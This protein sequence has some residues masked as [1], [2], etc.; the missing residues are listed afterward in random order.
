MTSRLSSPLRWAVLAFAAG[1]TPPPDEPA[2]K[3]TRPAPEAVQVAEKAMVTTHGF[4]YPDDP[5]GTRRSRRPYGKLVEPCNDW[6]P[7]DAISDANM[8]PTE[9]A[10]MILTSG[11]FD[12]VPGIE[13]VTVSRLTQHLGAPHPAPRSVVIGRATPL[14]R[15]WTWRLRGKPGAT[16]IA[17]AQDD[18]SVRYHFA[19]IGRISGGMTS[20]GMKV[21]CLIEDLGNPG[22]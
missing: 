7:G 5:P 1:C 3:P 20:A 14:G 10:Q 6:E 16:L 21:D 9:M 12:D 19:E 8:D 11:T 13:T 15:H 4:L 18:G 22:W 2:A 17:E